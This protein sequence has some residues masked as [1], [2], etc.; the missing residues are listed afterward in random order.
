[1]TEQHFW[2]IIAAANGARLTRQRSPTPGRAADGCDPDDEPFENDMLWWAPARAYAKATNGGPDDL[3]ACAVPV[4]RTIRGEPWEE[5][6]LPEL[7]PALAE[8][9]GA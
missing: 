8:R 3:Y 5:D 4:A 9:F 6:E 2:D 7:Y 1:M